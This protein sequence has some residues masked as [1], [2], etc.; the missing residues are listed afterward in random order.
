MFLSAC[1]TRCDETMAFPYWLRPTVRDAA[2]LVSAGEMHPPRHVFRV[3]LG[4]QALRIPYRLYYK[5]DLLRREL[6][7]AQGAGKLVL[8]CL[9]TRH[10]DGYLRQEAKVLAA[11]R[12][13]LA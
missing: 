12:H 11:L 3:N 8:A 2:A 6:S 10:Y 7:N 9:G 5:P 4:R 1:E 13:A